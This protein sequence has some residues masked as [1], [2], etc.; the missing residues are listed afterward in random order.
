MQCFMFMHGKIVAKW[1]AMYSEYA[2]IV[3]C[4]SPTG[5]SDKMDECMQHARS[6]TPSY[7]NT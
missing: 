4:S 1:N 3:M 7:A 5:R 6:E 2:M